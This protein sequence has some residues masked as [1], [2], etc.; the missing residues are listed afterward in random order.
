MNIHRRQAIHRSHANLKRRHSYQELHDRQKAIA[1]ILDLALSS[2]RLG[3]CHT[4]DQ[5]RAYSKQ[6]E[7]D[8]RSRVK[9]RNNASTGN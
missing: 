5:I 3:I 6:V 1:H 9:R 7:R 4:P 2:T 8:V